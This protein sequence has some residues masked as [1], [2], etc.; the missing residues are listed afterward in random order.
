MQKKMKRILLSSGILLL[1]CMTLMAQNKKS[2]KY[3]IAKNYFIKNNYRDSIAHTR[4]IVSAAELDE[5]L[6]MA[7][8]MGI[9]GKPTSIDF[10]KQY[11]I[12][13]IGRE[14][15]VATDFIPEKLSIS[16][17]RRLTFNYKVKIGAKMTSTIRPFTMIV[18][19]RKYMDYKMVTVPK[20]LI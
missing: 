19:D 15:N 11:V 8:V 2:V 14:T 17:K 1:S 10:T 16:G 4:K 6:G 9:D 3:T 13:V 7:T 5:L 12:V 18:V 20:G